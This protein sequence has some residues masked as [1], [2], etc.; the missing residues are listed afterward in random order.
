M[1]RINTNN[2]TEFILLEKSRTNKSIDL[3]VYGRNFNGT[4]LEL[5][6]EQLTELRDKINNILKEE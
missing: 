4:T 1:E 6:K 5:T 3:T 2:Q